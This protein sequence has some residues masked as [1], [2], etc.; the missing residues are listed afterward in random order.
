[1]N[2]QNDDMNL[3]SDSPLDDIKV[4][5]FDGVK[6]LIAGK[7]LP[8][9]II[10]NV[11]KAFGQLST[12]AVDVP[13][14]H[15]QGK[16]AEIRAE[17]QARIQMI[18]A[19][20]N[21]ITAQMNVSP[22]YA[23]IAADKFSQKILRERMNLDKVSKVA[24]DQIQ[25]DASHYTEEQKTTTEIQPIN[26][27]WLNHFE[28][29]TGQ[30]STEEMQLLFGRILAGEIQKPSSYSIKTVK[31]LAQLDSRAAALFRRLCSLCISMKFD[32]RFITDA[33]VPSLGGNA[34][35]NSLQQY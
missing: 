21:Q 18:S 34:A 23:Q 6:N 19:S 10:K 1:M 2:D 15:L 16:A 24:V 11:L 27:D 14:A 33:R 28:H 5:I 4:I 35:S 7:T 31:L 3:N 12:A 13:V 9:A 26:D 17:Y 8:I 25:Q 20:G 30:K 22:E 29:E 32:D